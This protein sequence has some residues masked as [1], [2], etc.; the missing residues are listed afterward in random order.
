MAGEIFNPNEPNNRETL[1]EDQFTIYF[2]TTAFLFH[3]YQSTREAIERNAAY[4]G[5]VPLNVYTGINSHPTLNILRH[6][7]PHLDGA[8]GIQDTVEVK[9][10]ALLDERNRGLEMTLDFEISST[11]DLT[12]RPE[13]S[14]HEQRRA[15][16]QHYFDAVLKGFSKASLVAGSMIHIG[17]VPKFI[18]NG[19]EWVPYTPSRSIRLGMPGLPSPDSE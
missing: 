11:G 17:N 10:Y 14:N 13:P 4:G 12:K 1:S 19:R 2:S 5:Y 3:D 9:D 7:S 16:G 8:T 6:Y 18:S 15:D